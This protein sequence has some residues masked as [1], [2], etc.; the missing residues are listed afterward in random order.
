[1]LQVV[2]PSGY[3][4]LGVSI[5][6]YGVSGQSSWQWLYGGG[7]GTPVY[8]GIIPLCPKWL[9]VHAMAIWGWLG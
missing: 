6:T 8:S 5:P 1:M 7:L 2:G 4:Y 3:G 9:E